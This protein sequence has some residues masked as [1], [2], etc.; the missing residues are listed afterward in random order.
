[1]TLEEK[2]NEYA[3][4]ALESEI[5]KVKNAYIDGYNAARNELLHEPVDIDGV[6]YHDMSLPSGTWW[7]EV[8]GNEVSIPIKLPY[9]QVKDLNLPTEEDWKEL[10]DNTKYDTQQHQKTY[11]SIDGKRI[12]FHINDRIWCKSDVNDK[13]EALVYINNAFSNHFIG[14]S[15]AIVLVKKMK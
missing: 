1:M 4:N 3:L 2:A 9:N 14:E 13:N 6:T 10:F 11:L 7:S 15:A 8:I 12:G 5:D